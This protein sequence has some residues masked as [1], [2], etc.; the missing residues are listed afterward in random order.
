MQLLFLMFHQFKHE[1]RFFQILA[2]KLREIRRAFTES[3]FKFLK[4]VIFDANL[5]S[6]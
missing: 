2:E 3:F 6:K 1:K 4:A 5:C